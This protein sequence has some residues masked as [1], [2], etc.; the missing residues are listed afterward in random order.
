MAFGVGAFGR[1]LHHE[2][3]MITNGINAHKEEAPENSSI[4]FAMPFGED[5]LL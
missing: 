5:G 2:D 1:Y 4:P 3:G